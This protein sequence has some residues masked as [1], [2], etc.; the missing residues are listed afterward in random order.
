MRSLTLLAAFMNATLTAWENFKRSRRK[1][2]LGVAKSGFPASRF[3]PLTFCPPHNS[4]GADTQLCRPG[5]R[6]VIRTKRQFP[7]RGLRKLVTIGPSVR[8]TPMM[9]TTRRIIAARSGRASFDTSNYRFTSASLTLKAFQP[10]S[11][12]MPMK[13]RK[14]SLFE[15]SVR[16]C[17]LRRHCRLHNF[18]TPKFRFPNKNPVSTR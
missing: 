13:R 2:F 12:S 15:Y 11:E 3:D 17:D 10:G 18:S 14:T 1:T 8:L 7:I 4:R 9:R 6:V 5:S 16:R